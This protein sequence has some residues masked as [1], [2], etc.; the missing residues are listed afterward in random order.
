[1]STVIN[2]TLLYQGITT[3]SFVL[4]DSVHIAYFDK[5]GK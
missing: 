1:M 3:R 4:E 2:L 5:N